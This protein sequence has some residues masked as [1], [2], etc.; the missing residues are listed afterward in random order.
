MH[1]SVFNVSATVDFWCFWLQS[2][3]ACVYLDLK[4]KSL[5]VKRAWAKKTEKEEMKKAVVVEMEPS[6]RSSYL[7]STTTTTRRR[8]CLRS[9]NRERAFPREELIS[10]VDEWHHQ[11]VSGFA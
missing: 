7:L 1:F 8:S 9:H 5:D 11:V 10:D 6:E 4:W 3:H 2:Q